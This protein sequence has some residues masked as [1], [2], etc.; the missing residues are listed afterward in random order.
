M[1]KIKENIHWLLFGMGV[2]LLLAGIM[3]GWTRFNAVL[4]ASLLLI[5]SGTVLY[6]RHIKRQSN[7]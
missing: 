3:L 1:K 4:I 6:V 2:L 5:L 7:Y